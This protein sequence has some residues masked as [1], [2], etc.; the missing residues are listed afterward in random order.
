MRFSTLL[1]MGLDPRDG[2]CHPASH[3]LQRCCLSDHTVDGHLVFAISDC[4]IFL[5]LSGMEA[6]RSG[7]QQS[8]VHCVAEHRV[9]VFVGSGRGDCVVLGD[10]LVRV[11]ARLVVEISLLRSSTR[12]KA[13]KKR[14]VV[15]SPVL[16]S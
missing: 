1:G 12:K 3:S 2:G 8:Y 16:R 14:T 15:K 13:K 7:L 6:R 5:F 4:R 11:S 9:G 10:P